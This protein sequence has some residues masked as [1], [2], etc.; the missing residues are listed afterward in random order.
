[1][2]A[3]RPTMRRSSSSGERVSPVARSEAGFDVG[4]GNAESLA[5]EGAEDCRH[6]VAVHDDDGAFGQGLL[7]LPGVLERP[8]DDVEDP[9]D[10]LNGRRE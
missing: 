10:H 6:G 9:L 4:H 3:I 1:M 2:S 7:E 8:A 5:D